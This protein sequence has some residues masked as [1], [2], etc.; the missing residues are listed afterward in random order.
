MNT[1][2]KVSLLIARLSMGWFFLYAGFVKV[3]NP[4]FSAAGYIL[5]THHLVGLY[6]WFAS[7]AI[8]PIINFLNAWGQVAIGLALIV[9]L[10]TR[11]T[12]GVGIFLMVMYYIPVLNFPLAGQH[13]YIIDDHI[14]YIATFL[15]LIAFNAGKIWGVDGVLSRRK[16]R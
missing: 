2:Q 1:F 14:L 3:I 13:G 16:E 9:G 5:Q 15:I 12:S 4:D 8:L 10:L 6:Q 11:F 7:P